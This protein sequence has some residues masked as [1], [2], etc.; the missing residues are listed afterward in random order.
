MAVKGI[1]GSGIGGVSDLDRAIGVVRRFER[2]GLPRISAAEDIFGPYVKDASFTE[3][4]G[5]IGRFAYDVGRTPL[6]AA[7]LAGVGIG[8]LTDPTGNIFSEIISSGTPRQIAARQEAIRQDPANR[9]YDDEILRAA[10]KSTFYPDEIL[11]AAQKD[12]VIRDPS[13]LGGAGAGGVTEDIFSAFPSITDP[14]ALGGDALVDGEVKQQTERQAQKAPEDLGDVSDEFKLDEE[15]TETSATTETVS[16]YQQLLQESINSYNDMMGLAPSGAKTIDEYKK[17][18]SEA[19]GI[20]ISGEP[21]NRAALI[22]FGT[23]L[24]Q[25][26]AG[27]GFNVA[28]ILSDVGAA[29]EKALPVMERARQEARQGQIAAGKFALGQRD[30]DIKARQGFVVDQMKYLRDRRDAILAA[31]VKRAEKIED[32]DALAQIE[33]NKQAI[34]FEYDWALK[35]AQLEADALQKMREGKFKTTDTKDLTDPGLKDIKVTMAIRESDGRAVYRYP[36]Q[37]AGI[38]GT[39]Y[40]DTQEALNTTAKMTSIIERIMNEPGG[41]NFAQGKKIIGGL[42]ASFGGNIEQEAEFDKNGNYIGVKT[43][44]SPLTTLKTLQNRLINQYKRFLTQETGNGISNVDVQRVEELLGKVNFLTDPRESL[45]AIKQV[46][47]IFKSKKQKL[48]SLLSDFGDET[49]YLNEQE[50]LDTRQ[51]INEKIKQSYGY[52]F[53]VPIIED[54]ATGLSVFKVSD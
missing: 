52:D 36:A 46:E 29:G 23:A 16:P 18:F 38:I 41:I 21:D 5:N 28:N 54:E 51:A 12:V 53:G 6:E 50:Y 1:A 25:N 14:S 22:A 24:M 44:A 48:G 9:P 26:K 13:A 31:E 40:A 10:R 35:T 8:A 30:A 42:I 39:H 2:E 33:R 37:Q 32:R 15:K 43:K 45:A 34:K 19:T 20:D 11:R 4:L 17:E 7:R 27:K 47:E 3:E 49:R